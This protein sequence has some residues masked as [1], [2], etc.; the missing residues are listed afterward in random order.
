VHEGGVKGKVRE[1]SE[2]PL[3]HHK[4]SFHGRYG[5]FEGEGRE[6]HK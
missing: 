6:K 5:H 1:R 2:A 4:P 3:P